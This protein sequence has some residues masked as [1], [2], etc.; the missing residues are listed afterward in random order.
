MIFLL[1]MCF[2]YKMREC[3]N[4]FA[5]IS[6]TMKSFCESTMC[7]NLISN[8]EKLESN[9]CI[10]GL[11]NCRVIENEILSSWKCKAR[12]ISNFISS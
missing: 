11:S 2:C 3:I 5:I 7:Y 6:L 10:L 12:V 1:S 8:K 9:V 4:F